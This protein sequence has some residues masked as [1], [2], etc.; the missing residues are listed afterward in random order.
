MVEV[1]V[2]GGVEAWHGV[3]WHR[4]YNI[5]GGLRMRL[6][7]HRVDCMLERALVLWDTAGRNIRGDK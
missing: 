7:G 1:W 6:R 2:Q 4:K 5:A 3:P